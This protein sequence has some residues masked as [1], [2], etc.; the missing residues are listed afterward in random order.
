M[1][2]RPVQQEDG[3]SKPTP[4]LQSLSR[5]HVEPIDRKSMQD[6]VTKCHYSC[7]MPRQT[8]LC[9]GGFREDDP[10]NMRAAISFGWGSRP[11]H[12]IAKLF[13]SLVSKDYLDIGKMCLEDS[14]PKNSES[15]F[16]ASSIKVLKQKFPDI[17]VLFTWAD[18]M[19][20]KPG[21]IYQASNF[22]YGGYI[23]TDVYMT[24]EGK[25]LHPLQLQSER[26]A[27]GADT[28][29]RT[30]RPSFEE[31][32]EKGWKHYFGKQFR[33]IRFLCSD[34]ERDALLAESP[35]Q[36]NREYPKDK[37]CEWKIQTDE[38]RITCSKP[39]FTSAVKFIAAAPV[40]GQLLLVD[41]RT[42][43]VCR[44]VRELTI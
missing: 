2:E 20:G 23:W 39:D 27:R 30:Q 15:M 24:A 25:R 33:Y 7:V 34:K 44:K 42:N 4:S 40:A 1:E 11:L 37:D 3:G 19:W 10:M 5:Y 21:Y 14:E 43:G 17:K 26:R 6:F 13:P 28:K 18:G 16:L 8:K 35:F 29:Q 32:Q 9:L 36:W 38:G 41:T 31:Q 22:L 12:T